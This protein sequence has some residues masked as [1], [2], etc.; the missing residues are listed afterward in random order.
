MK[1][2]HEWE[3]FRSIF[4]V[5]LSNGKRFWKNIEKTNKNISLNEITFVYV[6]TVILF[7]RSFQ[8]HWGY[9]SALNITLKSRQKKCIQFST[10]LC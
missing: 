1:L 4:E 6:L 3:F 10:I 2:E 7:Y 9:K 5:K 8:M